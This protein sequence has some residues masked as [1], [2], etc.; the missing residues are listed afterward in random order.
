MTIE[1]L[2]PILLTAAISGIAV[3][4]GFAFTMSRQFEGLKSDIRNLNTQFT[5]WKELCD[6]K[7]E[8]ID[9]KLKE[10]KTTISKDK[11]DTDKALQM[12]RQNADWLANLEAET[13]R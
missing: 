11:V 13:K 4:I 8:P 10:L 3:G 12:S 2:W 7:H 1:T 5:N 9:E 6:R